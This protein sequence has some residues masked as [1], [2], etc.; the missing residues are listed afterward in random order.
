MAGEF[1]QTLERV[2]AKARIVAQR[3]KLIERQRDEALER[4]E[5]LQ[6]ELRRRD[7][8][9][10][11]LRRQVEFLRT[12]TTIAPERADVARARALLA[13]LVREIDASIADLNN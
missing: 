11:D 5:F 13:S 7:R 12:A 10:L 3:Y 8:E 1:Q 9:I 4:A 6:E 2:A